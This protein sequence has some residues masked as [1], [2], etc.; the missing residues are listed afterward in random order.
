MRV[1]NPDDILIVTNK[2]YIFHVQEELKKINA[3]NAHIIAEPCPKNT[4]P[5]IT[6]AVRYCIDHLASKEDEEIFIAPSDHIISPEDKF[7]EKVRECFEYSHDKK[8]ITIGITPTKPET[9]YGYIKTSDTYKQGFV[10]DRFVEKPDLETAKRYLEES[11][12]FWNSG[13][14][15]FTLNTFIEELKLYHSELYQYVTEKNYDQ[16]VDEFD[17]LE[18]ISIDYAIAEKSSRI[19]TL[20]LDIYWNDVGSWDSLYDYLEKDRNG[21]VE[22]G[23]CKVIDCKNSMLMSTERLVAAVGLEDVIV[24]ETD[25]VIMAAKKGDSQRVK[26]IF[27]SIKNRNEAHEH[28]TVYRPWGTYTILSKG[29]GYKVKKIQ[30]MPGRNLSLQTHKHRS[31]HWIVINGKATIIIGGDDERVIRKNESIYVPKETKHRLMNKE[32]E[33]LE[34]IE[35]Q[36]GEY[37]GEDDITRY[38][39]VYGR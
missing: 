24:I 26:E 33:V 7:A 25:D 36:N 17:K 12:Y 39:D 31:E 11:G 28:T 8:L 37:L 6:L 27:D 35:V 9:G 16:F 10:V 14:Y 21:N 34:I 38:D 2:K 32:D 22:I 23:D 29:E 13:M 3:Q 20:P 1:V 19:V 15:A 18:S 4:A 30:V 5:A